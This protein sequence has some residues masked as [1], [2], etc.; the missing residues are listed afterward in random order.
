[1]KLRIKR[2]FR[3][4]DYTIGQLY[5]D[6]AYFCDTLEDTD[7][8]LHSGMSADAVKERKV[9]GRTAIPEGTYKVT[10]ARSPRFGRDL[11]KLHGVPGFSGILIHAGNSHTDT[12][13]CILV[14]ENRAKGRVLNSRHWEGLLLEALRDGRDITIEVS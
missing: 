9:S 1:M 13:G 5:V 8:G 2:T 12:S 3:G 6:G 11:P 4:A 7:R 14:G 10:V